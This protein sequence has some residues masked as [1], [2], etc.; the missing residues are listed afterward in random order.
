M[1]DWHMLRFYC[2]FFLFVR[3]YNFFLYFCLFV[4]AIVPIVICAKA[5]TDVV[6]A[7]KLK[8]LYK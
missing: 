5:T 8:F 6:A 2:I 3:L 4:V 7:A 1:I